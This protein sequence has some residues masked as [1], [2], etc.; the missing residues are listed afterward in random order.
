MDARQRS[1]TRCHRVGRRVVSSSRV[2]AG[3][4]AI[5]SAAAAASRS[6]VVVAFLDDLEVDGDDDRDNDNSESSQSDQSEEQG[7]T[8]ALRFFRHPSGAVIMV[9]LMGGHTHVRGRV[10]GLDTGVKARS[11]RDR[12]AVRLEPDGLWGEER[13]RLGRRRRFGPR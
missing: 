2:G 6:R 3:W 4:V 12:V 11:G 8:L 10:M 13:V 5:G 9:K 7:A 1:R